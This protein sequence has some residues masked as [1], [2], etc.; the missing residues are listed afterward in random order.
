M[1]RT[2][3]TDPYF[4]SMGG[5]GGRPVRPCLDPS[6]NNSNVCEISHSFLRGC[7][8]VF[9]CLTIQLNIRPYNAF[10]NASRPSPAWYTFFND[11]ISS[12]ANKPV[13]CHKY[14]PIYLYIYLLMA[15]RTNHSLLWRGNGWIY[16]YIYIHTY[17]HTYI[18][19]H[20]HHQFILRQKMNTQIFL[21][22]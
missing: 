19:H 12:P 17:I 16:C 3:T 11:T 22:K 21:N 4:W 2:A 18:Y 1:L 5:G 20:H 9:I 10:A 7:N 13:T 15:S 6:V 8:K 14:S